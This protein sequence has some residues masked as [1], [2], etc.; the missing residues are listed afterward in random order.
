[1]DNLEKR[2]KR[3]LYK[4]GEIFVRQCPLIKC[5][6]PKTAVRPNGIVVK[7]SKKPYFMIIK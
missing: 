7:N 6:N 2:D 3:F 4:D 5:R 1:M